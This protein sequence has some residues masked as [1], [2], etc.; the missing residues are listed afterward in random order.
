VIGQLTLPGR[1]Y[2]MM[3]VICNIARIGNFSFEDPSSRQHGLQAGSP[4]SGNAMELMAYTIKGG[5]G[6]S[7]D[8][9]CSRFANSIPR[10][11]S[12]T[13]QAS[14]RYSAAVSIS[15][16]GLANGQDCISQELLHSAF[17]MIQDDDG[18]T[19]FAASLA[20]TD[21][22][23]AL[24]CSPLKSLEIVFESYCSKI[25][26]TSVGAR[27]VKT[28]LD[29]T[30]QLEQHLATFNSAVVGNVKKIFDDDNPNPLEEVGLRFC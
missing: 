18:D 25:D 27:L 5:R 9:W 13:L 21:D 15:I 16:S 20:I 14:V 17:D 26:T 10:L 24:G 3:S 19:R 8:Q 6:S 4:L 22:E 2:E 28:V 7:C 29:C 30:D 1:Q 23:K 11:A 12:P